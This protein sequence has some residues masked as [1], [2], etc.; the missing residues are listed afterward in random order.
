MVSIQQRINKIVEAN[1]WVDAFGSGVGM[2][3]QNQG[4][5]FDQFKGDKH[6]PKANAIIATLEQKFM[7]IPGVMVFLQSPP[8]ITLG[9]NEGRSQYSVA[10]Q[11]VDT[12]ELYQW[13]PKLEAKLH[14]I[15]ELQDM[16]SDLRL[17]SPRLEVQIDRNRA[18]ALGVTPDT[19]ANTLYDAYGSRKVGTITA[20]SNQY[21]V[22]LEVL[23]QYQR[24]PEE[25][26][27]LYIRSAQGK[28]VPLTAVAS[29]GRL[30]R[31]SAFLTS[32]SCRP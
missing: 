21:D 28:L 6:R 31:R 2:G 24:N 15:P 7:A 26:S 11:D 14:S 32:V 30:S 5:M 4:F 12:A 17:S 22:L 27:R 23:P 20:A 13:A 19:I 18:L 8:L 9:Q 29:P 10:L 16:Y 3:G 25:L 1:P